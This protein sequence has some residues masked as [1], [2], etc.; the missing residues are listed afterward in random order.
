MACLS[1][2]VANAFNSVD[3]AAVLRVVY[4]S[5]ELAQCWGMVEFGYGSPSLLL[6]RC[7]DTVSDSEAF[8]ESQ[9][10][11]RQGDP[12]AGLLSV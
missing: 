2:D 5:P 4:S 9:T 7:D 3:R 6:M 10:G 1:V 8:V 12:L 11:V